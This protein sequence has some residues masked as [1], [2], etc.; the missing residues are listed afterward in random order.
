M[1]GLL[2]LLNGIFIGQGN[3][4]KTLLGIFAEA[5]KVNWIDFFGAK[6]YNASIENIWGKIE[7]SDFIVIACPD[8]FHIGWMQ[9][10]SLN[11]Y[12]G[13]IFCEKSPVVSPQQLKLLK[14]LDNEKIYFN[15]P[16][17]FSKFMIWGSGEESENK[18][19][20]IDWGHNF[21]FKPAYLSN[22]RS[23]SELVPY[24]V[25]TSLAI[26]FVHL[27][28]CLYGEINNLAI[29]YSN[30]AKTGTSPDTVKIFMSFRSR[31]QVLI[32]CSYAIEETQK[33]D[34][35]HKHSF[36]FLNKNKIEEK[37]DESLDVDKS[38][39]D[40]GKPPRLMS[41][42]FIEGNVKSVNYFINCLQNNKNTHQ[43]KNIVYKSLESLFS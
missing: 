20:T 3:F 16:L 33:L 21:A 17:T 22:W 14:E 12:K 29:A 41:D 6:E 31:N 28:L 1:W 19:L 5:T 11:K 24:G 38:R 18:L 37:L 4:S 32:N 23:K 30:I 2:I 27:A 8:P 9:I 36:L 26:H 7:L 42:P 39:V 10:L 43:D 15:F 40:Y 13:M 35:D 25:G 34:I